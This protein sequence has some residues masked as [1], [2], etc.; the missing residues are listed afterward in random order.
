LPVTHRAK[1][2][3]DEGF[4]GF[5][6]DISGDRANGLNLGSLFSKKPDAT[7]LVFWERIILVPQDSLEEQDVHSVRCG[8]P[9]L[10]GKR[11]FGKHGG[12]HNKWADEANELEWVLVLYRKNEN[13][14]WL[15]LVTW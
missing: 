15:T 10:C 2:L 1:K 7:F 12:Q 5:F 6:R 3:V 9:A 8:S 11:L 13:E 14:S 4:I